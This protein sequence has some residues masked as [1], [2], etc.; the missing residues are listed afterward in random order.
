MNDTVINDI[1]ERYRVS[2]GCVRV[3]LD[4]LRRTGGTLAQFD[5]PELGG[6]GQWQPGMVM[7]GDM[8]NNQLKAHVAGLCSELS[9]LVRGVDS[10][11]VHTLSRPPGTPAAAGEAHL[12]A[13]ESWW[14]ATYGHPSASGAQNGIR[15]AVFPEK[16]RLLIQRGARIDGYDTGIYHVSGVGQQQGATS[17]LTFTSRA[18]EIPLDELKKVEL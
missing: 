17:T 10:A 6:P 16:R 1:A 3:L 13:G 15:Y 14:P 12:P 2:V 11:G 4:S 7:V 5:H 9:A 18:G 8:M